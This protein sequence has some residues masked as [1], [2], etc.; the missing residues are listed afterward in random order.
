[1]KSRGVTSVGTTQ[2]TNNTL[3][4]PIL[5]TSISGPTIIILVTNTA[6]TTIDSTCYAELFAS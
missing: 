5:T 6:L 2:T 3:T 1:M 4:A